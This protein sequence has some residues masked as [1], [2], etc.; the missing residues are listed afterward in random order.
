MIQAVNL[1]KGNWKAPDKLYPGSK[2]EVYFV[3]G[4]S[5]DL[6]YRGR[7]QD[8]RRGLDSVLIAG[9]SGEE[10]TW[11]LSNQSSSFK[12]KVAAELFDVRA[13]GASDGDNMEDNRLIARWLPIA[14]ERER[15]SRPRYLAPPSTPLRVPPK[16]PATAISTKVVSARAK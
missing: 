4:S 13:S 1:P 9:D 2:I 16:C 8:L 14:E 5:F 3:E 15:S 11:T 12:G 6:S 7:R 10:F